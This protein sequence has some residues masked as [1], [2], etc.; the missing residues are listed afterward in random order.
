MHPCWVSSPGGL[1][2]CT[3]TMKSSNGTRFDAYR[4][5][6]LAVLGYERVRDNRS[7]PEH[8]IY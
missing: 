4:S 3:E 1:L 2:Y 8:A 5:L 6:N 7:M